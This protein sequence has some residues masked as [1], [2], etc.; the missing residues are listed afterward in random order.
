MEMDSRQ[1]NDIGITRVQAER[2][3]RKP[4]WQP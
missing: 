4:F 1:L 3:A 2:E